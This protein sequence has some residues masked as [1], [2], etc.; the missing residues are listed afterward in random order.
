MMLRVISPKAHL[1][2]RRISCL[3]GALVVTTGLAYVAERS[4][5]SAATDLQQRLRADKRKQSN[6]DETPQPPKGRSFKPINGLQANAAGVTPISLATKDILF[7]PVR[8]TIYA[9]VP[10][11]ANANTVVSLNPATGQIEG[12]VTTG[13]DPGSMALSGDGHYL[14]VSLDGPGSMRRVDL[15]S[16]S[17]PLE[18]SLGIGQFNRPNHAK[19]IEVLPGQPQSIAISLEDSGFNHEGVAVYDDA[20]QRPNKPPLTPPNDVIE[21]GANASTLFGMNSLTTEFGLRRLTIDANGVS[22]AASRQN[23]LG[24]NEADMQF[25]NGLL[26]GSNGKVVDP[27][28]LTLVGSF[29]LP[30]FGLRCCT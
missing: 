8:Q 20:T 28:T 2:L 17:Q 23:L 26:Y 16:P 11:G 15:Q 9:S 25:A 27:Q 21:F 13:S 30:G 6:K 14:Y 24:G 10:S 3:F 22:V 12:S 19:E 29:E 7:D 18:F 5:Q 4:T 1:W